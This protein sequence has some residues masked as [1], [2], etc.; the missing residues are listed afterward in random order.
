MRT[1]L[2]SSLHETEMNDPVFYL[3]E[4]KGTFSR[5]DTQFQLRFIVS[6]SQQLFIA[7]AVKDNNIH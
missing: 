6:S 5:P 2:A 3:C 4:F 7:A 1:E